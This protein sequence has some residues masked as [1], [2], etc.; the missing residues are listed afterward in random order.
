MQHYSAAVKRFL[1]AAQ[2]SPECSALSERRKDRNEGA[3]AI[4][5]LPPKQKVG[6]KT[7]GVLSVKCSVLREKRFPFM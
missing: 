4:L 3:H 1:S 7:K 5:L 2:G 6:N